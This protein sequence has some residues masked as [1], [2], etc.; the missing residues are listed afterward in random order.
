MRESIWSKLFHRC[1]VF[2]I[3]VSVF[4]PFYWL[5]MSSFKTEREMLSA[6]V[7]LIPH[8]FTLRHYQRILFETDY[9]SYMLNSL[10]VAVVTTA[11][12]LVLAVLSSYSLVYYKYPGKKWTERFILLTRMFPGVL[13]MIPIYV[14]MAKFRLLNTLWGLVVVYVTLYSPFAIMLLRSFFE[15]IPQELLEAAHIDGA[16]KMKTLYKVILPLLVPGLVTA[17]SWSFILSWSEYLFGI[18]LIN[19]AT[20]RTLVVGLAA[21]MGEYYIDWG[22]L[23]AGSVLVILPVIVFFSIMGKGFVKGLSAGAVKG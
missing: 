18:L 9:P 11:L 3:V 15:T 16:T 23:T 14:L 5:L 6:D 12:I 20:K 7:T 2:F 10:I 21:W 8:S 22:A 13:L 4:F 19:D 17:A 1:G